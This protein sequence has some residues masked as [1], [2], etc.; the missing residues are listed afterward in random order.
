MVPFNNFLQKSGAYSVNEVSGKNTAGKK[1]H[2]IA[3]PG[4]LIIVG[5]SFKIKVMPEFGGI[6]APIFD[7][8]HGGFD[9]MDVM[10]G[11]ET[12]NAVMPR[13]GGD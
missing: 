3:F 4:F 10:N 7:M 6:D 1:I 2:F 9:R 5:R 8:S 11:E 12:G 13:H